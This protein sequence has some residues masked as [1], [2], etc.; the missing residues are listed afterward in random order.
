MTKGNHLFQRPLLCEL[1]LFFLIFSPLYDNKW[2]VSMCFLLLLVKENCCPVLNSIM[3]GHFIIC[4]CVVNKQPFI[5]CCRPIW[6]SYLHRKES[7]KLFTMDLFAND[8]RSFECELRRKGNCKA[9]NK[10]HLDDSIIA[11]LNEYHTSTLT[12]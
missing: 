6:S 5:S 2:L 1:S 4:V 8:V 9:K 11:Q 3:Y 10:L 12:G 7:R